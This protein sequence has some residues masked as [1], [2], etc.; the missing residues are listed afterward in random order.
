MAYEWKKYY[1]L[2]DMLTYG[3]IKN[4]IVCKYNHIS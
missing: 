4:T 3:M 2:I 1:D